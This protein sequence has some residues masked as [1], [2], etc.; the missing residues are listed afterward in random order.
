MS[1]RMAHEPPI[2]NAR[3]GMI[4]FVAAE[5][6]LF[7]GLIVGYVVLRFGSGNFNGATLPIGFTGAS[8]VVIA[9]SS[10]MLIL[11]SRGLGRND[12]RLARIGS[13]GA[14][15]LGM[16]FL[17]LQVLEWNQLMHGGL[18]PGTN[19]LGGMFYALSWAH[20]LHVLGGLVLLAV[21]VAGAFRHGWPRRPNL[22]V[23]VAIYWHFVTV[24]WLALFAMLFLA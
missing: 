16:L 21:L 18:A 15:L 8:T 12:R 13:L 1:M 17:G 9:A 2:S 20:A 4:L 5:V 23:A 19:V 22:P 7:S 24:V 14:L 6:M 11:A 10:V 3:L